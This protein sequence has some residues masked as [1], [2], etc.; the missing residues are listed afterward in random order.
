M[1]PKIVVPAGEG[2][3]NKKG[4]NARKKASKRKKAKAQVA[5]A[6]VRSA[7]KEQ[8]D[9][10]DGGD[11]LTEPTWRGAK[12]HQRR[13]YAALQKQ[14]A[15]A[16]QAL[17]KQQEQPSEGGCLSK[18]LPSVSSSQEQPSEI[19]TI[20]KTAALRES[21][22]AAASSAQ[23]VPFKLRGSAWE[24]AWA[25]GGDHP[26]GAASSSS[27]LEATDP[28]TISCGQPHTQPPDLASDDED[29]STSSHSS[30][31]TMVFQ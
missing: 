23:D 30:G 16:E 2:T 13:A 27:Q 31:A 24:T 15:D 17:D 26:K 25:R 5:Q 8:A 22:E 4:K 9:L 6:D 10:Y 3:A 1:A 21:L 12:R 29:S 20:L 7:W 28:R 11:P 14:V 18:V 19:E